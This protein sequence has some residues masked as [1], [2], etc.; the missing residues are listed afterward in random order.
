MSNFDED[1]KNSAA[2]SVRQG[3]PSFQALDA[4]L[5]W[6]W[7]ALT[8]AAIAPEPLLIPPNIKPALNE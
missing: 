2:F 5:V 8:K 3:G 4:L 6:S 7:L 1:M